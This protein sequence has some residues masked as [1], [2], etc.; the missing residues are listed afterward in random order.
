MMFHDSSCFAFHDVSTHCVTFQ[1]VSSSFRVSHTKDHIDRQRNRQ[2]TLTYYSLASA[3]GAQGSRGAFCTGAHTPPQ[4]EGTLKGTPFFFM[5]S[6]SMLLSHSPLFCSHSLSL[7][8][9]FC[10]LRLL[11]RKQ[12]G[13]HH[14]RKDSCV[15]FSASAVMNSAKAL[16][17]PQQSPGFWQALLV[18]AMADHQQRRRL[19]AL[20]MR[21]PQVPPRISITLGTMQLHTSP[22]G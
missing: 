9:A 15:S 6:S 4:C 16:S 21:F 20:K 8:F 3:Q 12:P 19:G 5:F 11:S 14:D 13:I 17:K 1:H 18:Q 2:T 22:G 10:I 7:P